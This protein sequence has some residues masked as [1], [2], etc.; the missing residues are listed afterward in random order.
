MGMTFAL[1]ALTDEGSLDLTRPALP[2]AADAVIGALFPR[3]P[4]RRA[5]EGAL[6]GAGIPPRQEPWVGVFDGGALL[7][8]R[9]AFLYDPRILHA[10]YL[11]FEAWPDVHLIASQSSTNMFAYGRWRDGELVR[12]VS[13]NPVA[14]VRNVTGVRQDFEVPEVRVDTWLDAANA[15]L[16]AVLGLTGDTATPVPGGAG[17]DEVHL[18]RYAR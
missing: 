2:E 4:Y 13:V 5:G 1:L 15:T 3:T 10:R 17:W 16:A 6:G 14:G 8:T 12:S 7:A 11:R 9:D 18:Q